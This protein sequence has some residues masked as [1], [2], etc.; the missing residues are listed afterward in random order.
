M[1]NSSDYYSYAIRHMEVL[2][3]VMRQLDSLNQNM[4][5]AMRQPQQPQQP[6]QP[7]SQTSIPVTRTYRTTPSRPYSSRRTNTLRR[8]VATENPIN[9]L[10]N[11]L[12]N[13]IFWDPVAVFPTEQEITNA[14]TRIAYDELP[15][16]ATRCPITLEI[17]NEES[18]IIRIDGCG[19]CFLR[20]GIL[21]WFRN[22]V[23]CPVCRHDIRNNNDDAI[24]NPT[25]NPS[26]FQVDFTIN[27]NF[28]NSNNDNNNSSA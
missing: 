21:R 15:E 7:T 6:Q 13:S 1:N 14:T 4:A 26:A 22:H 2:T 19:H 11:N 12:F 27:P 18:E 8:T 3:S 28:R 24:E 17:F 25:E 10:A 16:D 9:T 23:S 20:N 5:F